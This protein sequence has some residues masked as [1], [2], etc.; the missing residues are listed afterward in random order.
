MANIKDENFM[1]K[2]NRAPFFSFL[3]SC[4]SVFIP[5]ICG[6]I[7]L[8]AVVSPAFVFAVQPTPTPDYAAGIKTLFDKAQKD[9][10]EKDYPEA[11]R[12]LNQ[13]VAKS[14]GMEDYI[15]KA[16]LL[17]ANLQE[18]FTISITQFQDLATEYADKPE[19]AEAEKSLGS[20]YYLADKYQDAAETYKEFLDRYSKSPFAPEARYWYASSLLALDQNK[21]AI[22][23]YRKVMHDA[24]D[25][26]WAPK[27]LL[28]V[29][30]AYFKMKKFGDAQKQYLKILDEFHFYDELNLVYLKLGE[31]YEAEGKFKEAHAAFQ[32][33]VDQ[34]PKS[35]E[36]TE[37]RDHLTELEKSH[38]DLPQ[39]MA[40]YKPKPTD[41]PI[42]PAPQPKTV[43]E[44]KL[45]P[46]TEAPDEEEAQVSKPFH[47]QIGV[48]SQLVN[49]T[50]ARK[51]V[52]EAGYRAYVVT[53]Q[54]KGVPYPV[55][56]VRVGN[57][58]DKA[59]AQKLADLMR[60]KTHEKAIVVED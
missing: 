2:T 11:K 4:S 60:R 9:F 30:N 33:L 15:P 6:S 59:G 8:F 7:F 39:T 51:Q 35:F 43:V 26:P 1:I 21:Q 29:G 27:A 47:V 22:D 38:P 49:V 24:P 3:P 40:S 32:T 23:E 44:V 42:P 13:V 46:N 36:V 25:S 12:L 5:F 19:G 20:R 52:K 16:R 45:M 54:A 57:F 14:S 55:Y 50:K 48:F 37:A 58:A 10:Q 56:K 41:T 53:V 28:G 31:T 17:L 18:D 34:F